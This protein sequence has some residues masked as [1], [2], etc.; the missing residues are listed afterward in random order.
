M[1]DVGSIRPFRKDAERGVAPMFRLVE[2]ERDGLMSMETVEEVLGRREHGMSGVELHEFWEEVFAT[3]VVT[4][5]D[6]YPYRVRVAWRLTREIAYLYGWIETPG[7]LLEEAT[8]FHPSPWSVATGPQGP[9]RDPILEAMLRDRGHVSLLPPDPPT[10]AL[11]EGGDTK[12][13]Y[14]PSKDQRLDLY[15]RVLKQVADGRL[16]VGRTREGRYGLAGLLDH[17]VVRAAMPGPR[18]IIEFEALLVRETLQVLVQETFHEAE[19]HLRERYDLHE[20]EVRQVMAMARRLARSRVDLDD[21]EGARAMCILRME[22]ALHQAKEAGD[23]RGRIAG[24]EKL[25]KLHGVF[26]DDGDQDLDQMSAVIRDVSQDRR[27]TLKPGPD[28][29]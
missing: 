4:L 13:S 25:A 16:N 19:N 29:G 10:K 27:K 23:H 17:D 26:R 15:V 20:H 24:I 3:Q 21:L 28:K 11:T 6:L 1:S 2:R 7:T 14:A 22:Q 9:L 18:E 12:P 5:D 8:G